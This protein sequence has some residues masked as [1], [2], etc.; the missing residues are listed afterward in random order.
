[1]AGDPWSQH[2]ESFKYGANLCGLDCDL[3]SVRGL[4]LETECCQRRGCR[5]LLVQ[6]GW[7][8]HCAWTLKLQAASFKL[9]SWSGIV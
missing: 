3:G 4:Y 5:A 8:A 1:M 9:D 7:A 2:K 6:L